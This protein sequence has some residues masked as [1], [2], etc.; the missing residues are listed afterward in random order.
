MKG[1]KYWK[2]LAGLILRVDHG[3]GASKKF[4][5]RVV[6]AKKQNYVW[7]LLDVCSGSFGGR[8]KAF[9]GWVS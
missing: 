1:P 6:K 9:P 2:T 3:R 5:S 8:N 4:F 7:L